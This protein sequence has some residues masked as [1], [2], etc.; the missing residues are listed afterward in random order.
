MAT[1]DYQEVI[2]EIVHETD[3]AIKVLLDEEQYGD[4]GDD[5]EIWIPRSQC[6]AG[7]ALSTGDTNP[8]VA[9]W[10]LEEKGLI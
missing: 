1:T 8:D 4:L 10:W 6:D 7:D 9:E 2:G 3:R 5:Q